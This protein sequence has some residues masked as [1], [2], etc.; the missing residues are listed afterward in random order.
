MNLSSSF[1]P[2]IATSLQGSDLMPVWSGVEL[3]RRLAVV[4][5]RQTTIVFDLHRVV[6]VVSDHCLMENKVDHCSF[7]IM[8]AAKDCY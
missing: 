8:H 6:D 7:Y 2:S 4:V 5:A 3:A 1:V